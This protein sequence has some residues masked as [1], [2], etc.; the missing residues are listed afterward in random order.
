MVLP[1]P[2][3][4]DSRPSP[5]RTAPTRLAAERVTEEVPEPCD[6]AADEA[7]V[8]RTP[9]PARRFT[10]RATVYA[11]ATGYAADTGASRPR[12]GRC[13]TTRIRT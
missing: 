2:A 11:R 12:T 1:D 9:A 13:H 5:F 6:R 4:T 10:H 7:G 3:A 8:F